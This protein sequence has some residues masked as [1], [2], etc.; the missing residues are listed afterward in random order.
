[1]IQDRRVKRALVLLGL[2]LQCCL[3]AGAEPTGYMRRTAS[4]LASAERALAQDDVAG[5]CN[6]MYGSADYLRYVTNVCVSAARNKLREPKE[7]TLEA[8]K[9]EASKDTA[10][11][12][13][14]GP[15]E[16]AAAK[17]KSRVA[18]ESFIQG[19]ASKGVDGER[20]MQEE[21]AKRQ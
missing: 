5:Y 17:T 19:V 16:V 13:A 14:M 8:A 20:L 15:P 11:C 9:L 4:T 18:R 1:M 3:A 12:A 2:G 7:C 10:Q 6:A 21:L